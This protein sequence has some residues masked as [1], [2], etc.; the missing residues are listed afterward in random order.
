MWGLYVTVNPALDIDQ[1]PLP[2]PTD[3][4][5][6][7]ASGKYLSTLDL[8]H[9]Y[10]QIQLDEDSKKYVTI[11]THRGLYRYTRLPF[12]VASVPALFQKSMD[13]VLQ[14]LDGVICYLDDIMGMRR[15]VRTILSVS[16]NFSKNMAFE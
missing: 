10:N 15:T 16:F 7:L 2:R 12:G 9:A 11:N 1:Y 8:L 5:A 4:F 3:L 6:T 14:G 13:I